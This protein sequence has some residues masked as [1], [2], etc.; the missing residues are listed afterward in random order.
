MTQNNRSTDVIIH[1]RQRD[2]WLFAGVTSVVESN[3]TEVISEPLHPAG[4]GIPIS[5]TAAEEKS[6]DG[7]QQS[8]ARP[9][10]EKASPIPTIR[11]IPQE[12]AKE[13]TVAGYQ[14]AAEHAAREVHPFGST[15][16]SPTGAA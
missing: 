13:L 2:G 3:K 10:H 1:E 16:G 5:T 11:L 4:P 6:F 7:L 8:D 14:D 15:D 9:K 12:N